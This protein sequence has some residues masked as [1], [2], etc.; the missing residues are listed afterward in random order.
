MVSF[1]LLSLPFVFLKTIYPFFRFGMFAEPVKTTVQTES[2]VVYY[3]T[4]TG[5]KRAFDGTQIGLSKTVYAN[6]MRNY[7]YKN[8]VTDLLEKTAT[9]IENKS[10]SWEMWHKHEQ[11]SVRVGEWKP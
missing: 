8:K 3:Q 7:Y 1:I 2:F 10:I 4:S 6:M 9:V 11:D 5:E